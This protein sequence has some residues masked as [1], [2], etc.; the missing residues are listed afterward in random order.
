MGRLKGQTEENKGKFA[1]YAEWYLADTERR[2]FSTQR[3]ICEYLGIAVQT[4]VK[5]GHIIEKQRGYTSNE[6][7][8]FFDNAKKMAYEKGNS[9][10]LEI[11]GK[12]KGYFTNKNNEQSKI[13]EI[14]ADEYYRI[15]REARSRVQE[16]SGESNRVRGMSA[17]FSTLSE[18]ICRDTDAGEAAEDDQVGAVGVSG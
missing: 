7:R 17:E 13:T 9:K 1:E 2:K 10:A 12:A 15:L 14:S 18:S 8:E 16:V 3:A 6:Q 5:W 11:L 4:G